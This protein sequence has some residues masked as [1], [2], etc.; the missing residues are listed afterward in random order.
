MASGRDSVFTRIV[1]LVA[2]ALIFLLPLK[3]GGL[4]VMPESGG[5]YPEDLRRRGRDIERRVL[6]RA[7]RAHLEHRVI[8]SG[9]RTIV[10]SA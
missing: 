7:V 5:F 4:A 1:G 6:T 2:A 10:F 9:H 8:I 3:F